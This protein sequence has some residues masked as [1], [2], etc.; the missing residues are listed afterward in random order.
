LGS[1]DYGAQLAAHFGLPYAYAY[2]FTEGAGVEEALSLYRRNYRP[3]ERYP[4]PQ[5][6]ICVWALA[7]DTEA[8][9]RRLLMTREHWRTGFEKG[10]RLPLESPEFAAGYPYTEAE[11]LMIEKLRLKATVGDAAQVAAKLY[12]LARKLELD[13]IVINTWTFDPAARR[14]SYKLLA[15]VFGLDP[16]S[17]ASS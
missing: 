7:A 16:R 8:E 4:H 6:T 3:T 13:E 10:L 17:K 15:Q 12:A 11:R 2:F 5:A 14:H 9:A 1:S